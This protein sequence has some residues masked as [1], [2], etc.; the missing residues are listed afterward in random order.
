MLPRNAVASLCAGMHQMR[1][2]THSTYCQTAPMPHVG[3][4]RYPPTL[5]T[6]ITVI[7]LDLVATAAGYQAPV[8]IGIGFLF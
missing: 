4:F 1:A 8:G 7:M 6:H 2:G 3:L 5:I